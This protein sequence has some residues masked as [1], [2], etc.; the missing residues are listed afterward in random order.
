M[1]AQYI[2]S[3]QNH[4]QRLHAQAQ[5]T[6][7]IWTAKITY[8]GHLEMICCRHAHLCPDALRRKQWRAFDKDTLGERVLQA[9]KI[10]GVG[11]TCLFQQYVT[12]QKTSNKIIY[13]HGSWLSSSHFTILASHPRCDQEFCSLEVRLFPAKLLMQV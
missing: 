10:S 13:V 3:I 12:Q 1:E 4:V 7:V 11:P 5:L 9:L 8:L 6:P 2:A